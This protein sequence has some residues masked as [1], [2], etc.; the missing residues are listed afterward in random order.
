[1][2]SVSFTHTTSGR[3]P[4]IRKIAVLRANA[5]GDFIITLPALMALRDTYPGAEIVLLGRSWHQTFLECRPGPTDR[6]IV[7]PPYPGVTERADTPEDRETTDTFFARMREEYFDLAIQLQGGGRHSN[8]FVQR[9]GARHTIGLR[10]PDA[11]PLDRSIAYVPYQHEVIRFLDTVG[12]VG[13]HGADLQP[14]LAV[15][16]SDRQESLRV[17]PPRDAPLIALHPGATD[18]ERIWP[19]DRFAAVADALTQH[20][21]EIVL[22][23]GD[24]D[25][26]A[27][28]AVASSMCAPAHDLGGRLSLG[29]LA[30]L[31]GRC[32]MM[33][34]NDSGP[35]HLA[36]SV[37]TPTV[38]IFSFFNLINYGPLHQEYHRPAVSW[39]TSAEEGAPAGASYLTDVT[40]EEVRDMA[41]E[42][43][44]TLVL[45]EHASL[46]SEHA[47]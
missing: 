25:R 12:L 36:A 26:A 33:L 22:V 8:P 28:D 13:A 29:G 23:G 43:L 20:G 21:S 40:V 6:V 10:T 9:L 4:N 7:V 42:L 14:H 30:G 39:R 15:T 5:L 31:L 2:S 44:N 37:G 45:T 24:E 35:R 46:S 11:A 3:L 34:G 16:S 38:G 32:L 18:P 19:P 41:L 1:M 47:P 17:L 27:I